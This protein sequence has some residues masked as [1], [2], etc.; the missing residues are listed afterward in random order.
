MK[1]S[2][3]FKDK[4]TLIILYIITMFLLVMLLIAFKVVTSLF[5]AVLVI[6]TAFFVAVIM[7]GYFKKKV[8]YDDFLEKLEQL[9]Q[10]YLILEMVKNPSFYEGEILYQ[11][12]YDINKSMI[13]KIK[14]Y[15]YSINN[16]KDYIE[17]WVH[18]VKIPIS[19]LLLMCH[20]N[21]NK[22]NKSYL[23][24]LKRLNN[25]VEQV[26]YYVRSENAEKDYL[27]NENKL[28]SIINKVALRCK[29]DIL[30]N[31]IDL[32]VKNVDYTIL[33]DAKWLEFILNQIINNSIKY[34]KK[35]GSYIKIYAEEKTNLI[36]LNIYDNGIGIP[37]SD[38]SKV[39][40]KSFTGYNGR[41]TST[42]T[43]MGLYIVKKLITKLGH[44]VEIESKQ[45]EYTNVKIYIFKNDEY[46]IVK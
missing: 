43:G 22:V 41:I 9:D 32:I 11:S 20:N 23:E 13:E 45:D 21:K 35:T 5:V 26:L 42:S 2:R 6:F 28:S 34:K 25:Y 27:I 24:Q 8:F 46:K 14:E 18:E 1:F 12:I 3:Y 36:I 38:L 39:F 40:N 33:T 10:K 16:F 15:E 31:K 30:E 29:D 7:I 19:S 4:L 44:K 37:T 17:M